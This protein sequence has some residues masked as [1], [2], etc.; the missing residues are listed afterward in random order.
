MN[1]QK[2][3]YDNLKVIVL[4]HSRSQCCHLMAGLGRKGHLQNIIKS[5]LNK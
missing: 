5:Q 4:Y 1:K 2:N 3:T